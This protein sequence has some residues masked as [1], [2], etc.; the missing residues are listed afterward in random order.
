M[1]IVSINKHLKLRIMPGRAVEGLTVRDSD[2]SPLNF[3]Y[4]RPR[5]FSIE[6]TQSCHAHPNLLTMLHIPALEAAPIGIDMPVSLH[7][8]DMRFTRHKSSVLKSMRGFEHVNDKFFEAKYLRQLVKGE[9]DAEGTNISGFF[10]LSDGG[11][12][13]LFKHSATASQLANNLLRVNKQIAPSLTYIKSVQLSVSFLELSN[14]C[15][16]IFS[17]TNF[18]PEVTLVKNI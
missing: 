10:V 4:K 15:T 5:I 2:T 16:V 13:L 18:V 9:V 11:A 6:S 17:G 3:L 1:R 14:F 12:V 8:E 7:L